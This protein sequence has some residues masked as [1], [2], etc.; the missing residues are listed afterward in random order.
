M[1]TKYYNGYVDDYSA[2]GAIQW[3][4]DLNALQ[5]RANKVTARGFGGNSFQTVVSK[6]IE[7]IRN[8]YK[9]YANFYTYKAMKEA[10]G[11]S[12]TED[13]YVK[14]IEGEVGRKIFSEYEALYSR[15]EKAVELMEKVE[16]ASGKELETLCEDADLE[17]TWLFVLESK[18]IDKLIP[19]IK[20]KTAGSASAKK[21][22]T[23][24]SEASKD[25]A[26][27]TRYSAKVER[28]ISNRENNDVSMDEVYDASFEKFASRN[29][30]MEESERR[31]LIQKLRFYSI[32]C[33]DREFVGYNSRETYKIN[34]IND[35][36]RRVELAGT[37]NINNGMVVFIDEMGCQRIAP[38]TKE[39]MEIINKLGLKKEDL[40]VHGSNGETP[41]L[42]TD[43]DKKKWARLQRLTKE[44]QFPL[45]S[46]GSKSYDEA[47]KEVQARVF[48]RDKHDLIEESMPRHESYTT[49]DPRNYRKPKVNPLR[50]VDD[51]EVAKVFEE[52]SISAEG[53]K[54]I[55]G[56]TQ[57]YTTIQPQTDI[58]RRVANGGKYEARNGFVLF[59]D[60][61]G[62][63]RIAPYSQKLI[64]A[65]DSFGYMEG[66]IGLSLQGD[67]KIVFETRLE[68][69]KWLD[70]ENEQFRKAN[71]ETIRELEIDPPAGLTVKEC[72][73]YLRSKRQKDPKTVISMKIGAKTV[74]SDMTEDLLYS[75][76]F[77]CTSDQY[78]DDPDKFADK[79]VRMTRRETF[80]EVEMRQKVE[81]W[82]EMI[83]ESFDP[84]HAAE[85]KKMIASKYDI[86][87]FRKGS[88]VSYEADALFKMLSTAKRARE[89]AKMEPERVYAENLIRLTKE[90]LQ[91]AYQ[92]LGDSP[93]ERLA[94]AEF[95][96]HS[97][98]GEF[99]ES[100]ILDDADLV[101]G[102]ESKRVKAIEANFEKAKTKGKQMGE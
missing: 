46:I 91:R 100:A 44:Q 96:S 79:N 76:L 66:E 30:F 55:S 1:A 83:D 49:I 12:V 48:E 24:L 23:L 17:H 74:T 34:P 19:Y 7:T 65:L 78:F 80:K 70:L 73:D 2:T 26:E 25:V 20:A 69:D 68:E 98:Y 21:I 94:I 18:G 53:R 36:N 102:P 90:D 99:F 63:Q 52:M 75:E 87:S 72:I 5:E 29:A 64:E 57:R 35:R 97:E 16:T 81:A 67:D 58:E 45:E 92:K 95:L 93:A 37:Y 88:E 42:T 8:R 3:Y 32:S 39:L 9:D 6:G 33:D 47:I 71:P 10:K 15:A 11:V 62:F 14:E 27:Y 61:K 43:D 89:S 13:D 22:D 50:S 31:E 101:Y 85:I 86:E 54:V 28:G 51:P 77:G 59:A 84:E 38:R 60:D 41:V 4:Q 56:M 40:P 82:S